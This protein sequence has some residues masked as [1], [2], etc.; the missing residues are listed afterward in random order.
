[1]ITMIY[2][3]KILNFKQKEDVL[4]N[5]YNLFEG[6]KRVLNAPKITNSPCTSSKR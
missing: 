1:M 5:I 3:V 4:K 6:R 2:L